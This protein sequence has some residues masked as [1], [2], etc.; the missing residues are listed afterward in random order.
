VPYKDD[1]A[2]Y[3]QI[4][5]DA[6]PAGLTDVETELVDF[7]TGQSL[8][9]VISEETLTSTIEETLVLS[10]STDCTPVVVTND[11]DYAVNVDP[12]NRQASEVEV[13]LLGIP[14]SETAKVLFDTVNIYD[15]NPKEFITGPSFAGYKYYYDPV[16]YTFNEDFGYYARHLPAES[17]IQ[18]YVYPPERSFTYPSDDGSGRFPGNYD[19]GSMVLTLASKRA[20]RYQPGRVTGFTMGVRMST[21]SNY[22]DEVIQWGCTNDYGDGY[23]FQLERGTDLYIVRTSPGLGT[24]KVAR[25]NW[26]GDKLLVGEGRTGWGLDPAK[27]TMYK[28]EFSWYGA[29]GASF[30]AYVPDGVGEGR[31]VRLHR[32]LAENQFTQPS[33]RSAYMKLF[34]QVYTTAGAT[35]AAFINLYG[36]SV[37]IDGG[38][39]GTLTM[40]ST[41][42]SEMKNIDDTGRSIL[43]LQMKSDINGVNNQKVAFPVGLGVYSSVAARFDLVFQGNEYYAGEHYY[44]GNGTSLS[45]ANSSP[46][47][48]ALRASNRL[49]I[50]LGQEFPDLSNEFNGTTDYLSGRRVRVVG[51][52]IF[53]THVIAING[54]RTQITTDRPIPAG[55]TSI[56]LARFDAYAVASGVI[57]SGVTSGTVFFSHGSGQWRLGALTSAAVSNDDAVWF[58]S[59]YAQLSYNKFGQIVGDKSLP[60]EPYRQA[61]FSITFPSGTANCVLTFQDVFN[62]TVAS[63]TLSGTTNPWPI[64]L[65]AELTPN[66]SMSDVVVAGGTASELTIPGSGFTQA[67]TQWTTISGL[68]QDSSSAG[69]A[70]YVANKFEALSSDPLSGVLVDKQ[71]Y[72]VL[73]S[74]Q[75]VGTYFVQAGESKQFDLTGLF[76]PEKMFL[77]GR[78]DSGNGALF[79]MATARNASGV[80]AAT[81]DWGEQ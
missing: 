66:C 43:G 69:G 55:T 76:R 53:N 7:A 57:A 14:R 28:I 15:I 59:K 68:T 77:T 80:V 1:I 48:V 54:T 5:E 49:E 45:R 25:D 29:V 67:I 8:I 32:I 47:F 35:S 50:A 71:G 6:S 37:Y 62:R 78:Y 51:A 4:P 24:L 58:A 39:N 20:F 13:S 21:Q 33:L 63:R 61:S 81:L 74:P 31:W 18:L 16:D 19:D 79:V 26:N 42:Q 75:R 38:D 56:R 2:N 34:T 52:G 60:D 27:V 22:E 10:T 44:Y 41:G 12:V 17:A 46:I 72:R 9:D 73:K 3:Y 30:L 36:S 11:S 64:S 65:V 70:T 40:G 23:Y